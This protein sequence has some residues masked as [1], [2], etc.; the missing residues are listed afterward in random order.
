MPKQMSDIQHLALPA[1]AMIVRA[2]H[3]VSGR[4]EFKPLTSCVA[5]IVCNASLAF[6]AEGCIL[7]TGSNDQTVRLW[8]VT[9]FKV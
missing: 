5:L 6:S 1:F 2:T 9:R 7:A 4:R 8:D 3:E